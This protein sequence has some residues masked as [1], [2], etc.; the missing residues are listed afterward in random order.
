MIQFDSYVSNGLKPPTGSWVIYH[1]GEYI[2]FSHFIEDSYGMS[3]TVRFVEGPACSFTFNSTPPQKLSHT[4]FREAKMIR[5]NENI[6]P[7]AI[8]E[9][10]LWRTW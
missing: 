3:V 1:H 2:D 5:Q 6:S 4:A 8:G 7:K 9:C 10:V